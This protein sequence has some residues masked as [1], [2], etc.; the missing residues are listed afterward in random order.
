VSEKPDW[1]YVQIA[2][3]LSR[4]LAG[5]GPN[6]LLPT[7][8]DL[9]AEFGVSRMTIRAAL[10]ILQQ[11][12]SVTRLRGRGTIANPHK[13]V[14]NAFPMTTVEEDFKRQGILYDTQ[15]LEFEASCTPAD[16]IRHALKLA[17]RATV[18]HFR[19]ARR[20]KGKIICYEDRYV[21]ADLARRVTPE[22]LAERDVLGLLASLAGSKSVT[23]EFETQICPARRAAA[24][25]LGIT[26]STMMV[27]NTFIH[28]ADD[29]RPIEAGSISYRVDRCSFRAIGQLTLPYQ[30]NGKSEVEEQDTIQIA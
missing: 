27:A 24:S 10:H 8:N 7:E 30:A 4:Q 17:A 25:A 26:P 5:L 19:L 2:D 23:V 1:G 22:L 14:R 3:E 11:N 29:G 20:V 13:I 6:T 16:T 18:G 12:G 15:V 9:A 28:F 21:V